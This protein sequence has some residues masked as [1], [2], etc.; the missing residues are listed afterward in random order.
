M[1]IILNNSYWSYYLT[2]FLSSRRNTVN[3]KAKQNF[4]LCISENYSWLSSKIT[5]KHKAI[6]LCFY[7]K[8][9]VLWK[10]VAQRAPVL[11]V[12]KGTIV[13]YGICNV[14]F[15]EI[16]LT[17]M[18]LRTKHRIQYLS[19]S[20]MRICPFCL[21]LSQTLSHLEAIRYNEQSLYHLSWDIL[22]LSL[23]SW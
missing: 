15:S 8:K 7:D 16:L 19:Q 23:L 9:N 2:V 20:Q 10:C 1:Q 14:L 11:Q 6:K 22:S 12:K 3:K 18:L 21:G 13:K 17:D 4:S 5:V